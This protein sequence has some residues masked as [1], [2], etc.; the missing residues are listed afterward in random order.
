MDTGANSGTRPDGICA[1]ATQAT[2]RGEIEGG[3][4]E[5]PADRVRS[6][7]VGDQS[8]RLQ[9]ARP[10]APRGSR[11]AALRVLPGPSLRDSSASRGPGVGTSGH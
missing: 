1:R 11:L 9:A 3:D 6:P 2:A 4:W 8:V 5:A 7:A 10:W